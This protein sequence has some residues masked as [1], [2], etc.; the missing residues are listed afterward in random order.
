M[1]KLD[2]K[3]GSIKA[4]YRTWDYETDNVATFTEAASKPCTDAELGL[5]TK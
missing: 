3:I 4:Y 2:E 5:I 1:M